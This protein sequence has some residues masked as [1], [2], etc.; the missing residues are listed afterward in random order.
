GGPDAGEAAE[1]LDLLLVGELEP[2]AVRRIVDRP[3]AGGGPAQV[4]ELRKLP[5][6]DVLEDFEGCLELLRL[7]IE[8]VRELELRF[9]EEPVGDVAV[10]GRAEAGAVIE[11]EQG[12]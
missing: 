6:A 7:I 11:E 9:L 1:G 5:R 12:E 3:L 2:R 8:V 10:L 4:Q